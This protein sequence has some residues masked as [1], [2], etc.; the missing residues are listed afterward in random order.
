MT[1]HFIFQNEIP[2]QVRFLDIHEL[3]PNPSP[4]LLILFF[5]CPVL[6]MLLS[7]SVDA[8]STFQQGSFASQRAFPSSQT[9]L[10]VLKVSSAAVLLVSVASRTR[11]RTAICQG[12]NCSLGERQKQLFQNSSG[13]TT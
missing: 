6:L 12:G 10:R 9:D 11:P 13:K 8:V 1:R 3:T 2:K 5:P 7:R 4:A